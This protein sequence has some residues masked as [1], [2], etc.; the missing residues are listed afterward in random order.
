[1]KACVVFSLIVKLAC[2]GNSSSV[3]CKKIQTILINEIDYQFIS[4]N[5]FVDEMQIICFFALK[6]IS[7]YIFFKQILFVKLNNLTCKRDRYFIE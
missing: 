3:N 6:N 2:Y 5:Y 4:T 1:M 7:L